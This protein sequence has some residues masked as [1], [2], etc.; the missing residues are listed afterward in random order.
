[1]QKRIPLLLPP[2]LTLLFSVRDVCSGKGVRLFVGLAIFARD[3]DRSFLSSHQIDY[4]SRLNVLT[5]EESPSPSS[6]GQFRHPL[7]C[8]LANRWPM[9]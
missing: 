4:Q 9:F 1:V 8:L 3:F 5:A 6:H 7:S 2:G